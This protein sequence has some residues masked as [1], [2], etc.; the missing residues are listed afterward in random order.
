MFRKILLSSVA[1][2]AVSGTAFAADL[3]SRSAPPVYLAPPPVFSWTGVYVGGQVG[4]Q[5]GSMSNT[6]S[7]NPPTG[8]SAPLATF[9]TNGVVGGAHLGILA[10]T[11]I[12][13]YGIEGDV[14][15]ASTKGSGSSFG[16]LINVSEREDVE[17]SFRLRGG[18]AFDR[19]LIY[20]TG[21]LA[22]ADFH[23]TYTSVLG[24]DSDGHTRFGW[25]VGGGVAYAITNS[26]SARVEYRYSDYGS[27]NDVLANSTA[28]VFQ[29]RVH[30]T[31]NAVRVGVSYNFSVPTPP[32]TPVV[33][34]Y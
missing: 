25:T 29:S 32:P 5:F 4:Y 14:E 3:P 13:V 30:E 2:V 33:A 15:G 9:N 12:F 34:K 1:F 6:L 22:I 28:G 7:A 27:T 31:D 20:A 23:N 26:V 21:G 8:V 19:A 10:Q 17:S 11:G 18:V 24:T 16:G